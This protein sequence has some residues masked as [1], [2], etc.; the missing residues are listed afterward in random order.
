MFN[1]RH[2]PSDG[3]GQYGAAMLFAMMAENER[4]AKMTP[5]ELEEYKKEEQRI[6]E[7]RERQRAEL[8]ARQKAEYDAQAAPFREQQRLKNLAKFEKW[9]AQ[10]KQK[11]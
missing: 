3:I 7:E 11:R 6:K 4:K 10:Q 9:Q 5:E 8:E 2:W 1:N